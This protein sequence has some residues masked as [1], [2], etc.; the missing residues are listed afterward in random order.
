MS[1]E[2]RWGFQGQS[3]FRSCKVAAST[4]TLY[5][6]HDCL[7]PVLVKQGLSYEKPQPFGTLESYEQTVQLR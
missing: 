4:C 7:F 5:S 1:E 6:A 3:L 2:G